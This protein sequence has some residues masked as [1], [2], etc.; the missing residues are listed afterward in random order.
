MSET[1]ANPT[2]LNHNV[3]MEENSPALKTFDETPASGGRERGVKDRYAVEKM[4]WRGT[5]F[6]LVFTILYIKIHCPFLNILI[7][8]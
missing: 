6:H 4:R 3:G 5:W 2:G 8:R 7:P 1:A